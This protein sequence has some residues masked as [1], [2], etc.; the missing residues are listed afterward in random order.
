MRFGAIDFET[1]NNYSD[2]AICAAGLAV[3]EDWHLAESR[4]WLVRPPKGSGYFWPSFIEIHGITHNDVFHEPEFPTIAGQLLPYLAAV[5]LVIAHNAVFDM[6]KLQGTLEHFGVPCPGFHYL[7]T[8]R[9][10]QQA[11]PDLASHALDALAEHIGHQ[12][13]HHHA[14]ADA[15]AAGWVLLAMMREKG[16]NTPRDLAQKL[17]VETGEFPLE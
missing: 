5:D 15:E 13:E 2:A 16:A 14:Q 4:Y 1:A 6:R 11:W 17:G 9:L 10:A 7:C 8:Y 3:F 12:F